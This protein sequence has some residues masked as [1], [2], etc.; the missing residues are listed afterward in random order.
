MGKRLLAGFLV[1]CLL[2]GGCSADRGGSVSSGAGDLIVMEGI[3]PGEAASSSRIQ[4]PLG[5]YSG[6]APGGTA[7]LPDGFI[8]TQPLTNCYQSKINS[9]N[10]RVTS[11]TI[12]IQD[13]RDP[14]EITLR[15]NN[16]NLGDVEPTVEQ[17]GTREVL[18]YV[19]GTVDGNNSERLLQPEDRYYRHVLE[20]DEGPYFVSIVY[21]AKGIENLEAKKQM[22]QIVESIQIDPP[23]QNDP[24]YD[25]FE[26]WSNLGIMAPFLFQN[27]DELTAEELQELYL[28]YCAC[29]HTPVY[30]WPQENGEW[31]E[32][33][34]YSYDAY[35]KSETLCSF[36]TDWFGK[37]NLSAA[38]FPQ[39]EDT[40]VDAGMV[41]LDYDGSESQYSRPKNWLND[42]YLLEG[43]KQGDQI[44]LS[45]RYYYTRTAAI[46]ELESLDCM[47]TATWTEHG[48][49]FESCQITGRTPATSKPEFSR[50]K[51]QV[52]QDL[53][54]R[55]DLQSDPD[56][57][58][59]FY[60]ALGLEEQG[61]LVYQNG[62]VLFTQYIQITDL[63]A[64]VM[65]FPEK[66]NI[67]GYVGVSFDC[68]R[69]DGS[70]TSPKESYLL[71][72][73]T[74]KIVSLTAEENE[75]LLRGSTKDKE[76]LTET[77]FK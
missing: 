16:R 7:G 45:L 35:V 15:H 76:K 21:T 2:L 3:S 24:I 63:G 72:C 36:G 62:P 4:I 26:A 43:R 5:V 71:S 46:P 1:M 56:L 64:K 38:D 9:E 11:I 18:S 32:I 51:A 12:T 55:T 75:I 29:T 13:T 59:V 54:A 66:L 49:L 47:V 6:K 34:S 61:Y 17:A 30:E 58:D 28:Y 14:N 31:E 22:L 37:Q 27:P 40:T 67:P 68:W 39:P 53:L 70:Y 23:D 57:L 52:P 20:F 19:I 33:K 25:T 60:L 77:L 73:S 48:P 74:G 50:V 42:V 8:C 41:L 10:G 69:A 44:T 65:G